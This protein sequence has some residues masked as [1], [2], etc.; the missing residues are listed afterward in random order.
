MKFPALKPELIVAEVP[1]QT[2]VA[3]VVTMAVGN[4]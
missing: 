1:G 4:G 3:E 2:P